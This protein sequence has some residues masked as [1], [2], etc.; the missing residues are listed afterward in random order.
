MFPALAG[1]PYRA[2]LTSLADF[3]L[4]KRVEGRLKVTTQ[5]DP[6]CPYQVSEGT[7][8]KNQNVL[9]VCTLPVKLADRY[10]LPLCFLG[11]VV[12]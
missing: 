10:E 12:T 7:G 4:P 6:G 9:Q 1:L 8:K 3:P 11:S 5:I 2:Q